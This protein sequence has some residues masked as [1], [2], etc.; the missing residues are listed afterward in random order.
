MA[1][2]TVVF[3][4]ITGSTALFESVGNVKAT[5][6]ITGLT[7]WI[8]EVCE[9][10]QGRVVKYTGDGV[11]LLFSQSLDAIE[12]VVELQQLHQKRLQSWHDPLKMGL[13]VGVARGNIVEQQGD[14][15]GDAVNIASR[16]SDL[17]GPDQ[18]LVSDAVIRE[19]PK[20]S[21][22][23]SHSLGPLGIRGRSET[24][25]VHQIEWQSG[26]ST[27]AFTMPGRLLPHPC[28][29]NPSPDIFIELS[30]L[31]ITAEFT[32]IALP[33]FMGRDI[34][35]QLVMKDPRV[36]RKHAQINWHAGKFHLEDTSS[37]GTWLRF[38]D[39]W[40]IISLRRQECALPIAGEI[41]L[42]ASFDDLTAPTVIFKFHPGRYARQ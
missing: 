24:C 8:G 36:S 5:E 33:V 6:T 18:I 17:S 21:L 15:Y 1:E 34:N 37:Y 19:L 42:G 31:D 40:A 30:W 7:S 41:A 16:L 14:C 4:D 11:L 32:S 39:S 3:A 29:G 27:D 20:N 12:A 38:S 9:N 26:L 13:Q 25:V 2:F 28:A 10:H 22:L 35:A 23:R